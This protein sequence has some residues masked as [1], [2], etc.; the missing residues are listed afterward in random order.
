[1]RWCRDVAA[2]TDPTSEIIDIPLQSS[3]YL[4]VIYNLRCTVYPILGGKGTL[5]SGLTIVYSCEGV[6]LH[7]CT[8]ININELNHGPNSPLW[9]SHS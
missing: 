9:V 8:T 4:S 5:C 1:M 3:H 6:L 2:K 7:E